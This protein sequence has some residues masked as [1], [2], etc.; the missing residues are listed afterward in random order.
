MDSD[1]VFEGRVKRGLNASF[2][3]FSGLEVDRIYR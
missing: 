1:R 2:Y 3:M